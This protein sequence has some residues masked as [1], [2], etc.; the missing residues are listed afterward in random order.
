MF[1]FRVCCQESW[2][3]NFS[4]FP[5]GIAAVILLLPDNS[6]ETVMM[7]CDEGFRIG[8]FGGVRRERAGAAHFRARGGDWMETGKWVFGF[9][10]GGRRPARRDVDT[11]FSRV[12]ACYP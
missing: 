8:Y 10:T 9:A 5:E 12:A 7:G 3:E 2:L 6:Q 4:Y 1:T 11:T